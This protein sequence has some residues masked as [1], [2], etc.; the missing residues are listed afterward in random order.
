MRIFLIVSVFTWL[1]PLLPSAVQAQPFSA[2][3]ESLK[4]GDHLSEKFVLDHFGVKIVNAPM[5]WTRWKLKEKIRLQDS[6]VN[7]LLVEVD[8]A[9]GEDEYLYVLDNKGAQIN[10]LHLAESANMDDGCNPFVTYERC[11]VNTFLVKD[12]C[13]WGESLGKTGTTIY[14]VTTSGELQEVDDSYCTTVRKYGE[15]SEFFLS[16]ES[17]SA[18]DATEISKMRN[19]IFAAHGYVFKNRVWK[20]Y[21]AGKSWYRPKANAK[22]ELNEYEKSNVELLLK[23]EKG[24]V[25]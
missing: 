4:V 11:S 24:G 15:L 12:S 14:K 25:E 6:D 13:Y 9:V 23:W 16:D 20:D 2:T 17:L 3:F 18:V 7:L 22:I 21:F 10:K 1:L 8:N 5:A 19:E